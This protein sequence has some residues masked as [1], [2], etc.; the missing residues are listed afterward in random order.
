M[1]LWGRALQSGGLV[2]SSWSIST[3]WGRR[4][5][6]TGGAT[7]KYGASTAALT[8]K[9]TLTVNLKKETLA[10]N[11][12]LSAGQKYNHSVLPVTVT[13][14]FD[15]VT[16]AATANPAFTSKTGKAGTYK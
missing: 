3:A 13:V 1:P 5:D 4:S 6:W 16:Y 14:S 10:V 11:W 8:S 15:G 9:G 7:G 12:G 2:E